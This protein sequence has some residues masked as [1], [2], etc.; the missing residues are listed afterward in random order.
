MREGDVDRKAP[1][2]VP[3]G[4]GRGKGLEYSSKQK[5]ELWI[6]RIRYGDPKERKPNKKRP[7]MV[8]V[9]IGGEKELRFLS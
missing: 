7:T 8:T 3:R 1:R 5:G 9:N 6:G 4:S 2:K